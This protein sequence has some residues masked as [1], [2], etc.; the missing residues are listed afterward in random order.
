MTDNFNVYDEMDPNFINYSELYK[1]PNEMKIKSQY[2]I[3]DYADALI[4]GDSRVYE[5]SGKLVGNRYFINTQTQCV[6][7]S[8]DTKVE[9][10]SILVDNISKSVMSEAT[11][12][13]KGLLYSLLASLKTLNSDTMFAQNK[14]GEPDTSSKYSATGYLSNLEHVPMPK[15]SKVEVYTDSNQTENVEGWVTE[16]DRQNIDPSA[17]VKEGFLDPSDYFKGGTPEDFGKQGVSVGK[18]MTAQ[19]NSI[20]KTTKKTVSD[21]VKN[22]QAAIDKGKEQAKQNA[23]DGAATSKKQTSDTQ[24]ASKDAAD[25]SKASTVKNQLKKAVATYLTKNTD[26]SILTLLTRLINSSYECGD[27]GNQQTLRISDKCISAIYDN[28]PIDDIKSKDNSRGDLCPGQTFHDIS[29]KNM[30]AALVDAVKTNRD[31]QKNLNASTV[32]SSS[33]PPKNICTQTWERVCP[34]GLGGFGFNYYCNM[35]WVK[36]TIAGSDYPVAITTLNKYRDAIVTEIV[37]YSDVSLYGTCALDSTNATESFTTITKSISYTEYTAYLY[38]V[39]IV[40][41]LCFLAYRCL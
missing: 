39:S 9:S 37:R 28:D 20:K 19:A 6:D 15:C 13:N 12:K 41:L 30:F 36:K 18:G 22:S 11:D 35:D 16:E 33:F 32:M 14:N 17:I 5:D 2:L 34:K 38:M 8:D 25:K 1:S 27:S 31:N 40:L 21:S 3:G 10:R 7:A 4:T 29:I 23:T 26:T 24:K